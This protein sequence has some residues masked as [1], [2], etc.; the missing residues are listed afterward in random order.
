MKIQILKHIMWLTKVF[1]RVRF[2]RRCCCWAQTPRVKQFFIRIVDV[3]EVYKPLTGGFSSHYWQIMMKINFVR[4]KN[5]TDKTFWGSTKGA[6]SQQHSIFSAFSSKF[7]LCLFVLDL[8]NS[9]LKKERE[10]EWERADTVWCGIMHTIVL[11]YVQLFCIALLFDNASCESKPLA[12]SQNDTRL[13]GE[14]GCTAECMQ[15]NS[16]AVRCFRRKN[17]T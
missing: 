6:N 7:L 8:T 10:R 5:R 17:L 13:N 16:T 4:H 11:K 12:A 1:R 14:V 3:I 9:A 15:T 2:K